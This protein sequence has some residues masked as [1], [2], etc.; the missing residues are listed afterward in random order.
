MLALI[1]SVLAVTHDPGPP[2]AF[3]KVPLASPRSDGLE[4]W[5]KVYSVM[6][7]P[8]CINCH[9]ATSYPQQGD[10]RRRHFANVVRGPRDKGVFALNCVTCHQATNADSTGVPGAHDW[11][12][13]PLSMKWQDAN[14]QPLSS[15]EVC[16]SVLRQL[17]GPRLL[18]PHESGP[19]LFGASNPGRPP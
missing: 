15:P 12:L 19:L 3:A 8:R 17:D 10:D 5:Q 14:D 2:A 1:L 6:V 16:R 4:A 18:K 11:H 13:A 7:S 9:T